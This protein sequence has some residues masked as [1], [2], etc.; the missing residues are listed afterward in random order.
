VNNRNVIQ[1]FEYQKISLGGKFK[2]KHLKALLK[3]N[4]LH[5]FNYLEAKGNG[6]SF[7]NYVGIVQLDELIIEI[8]PKIDSHDSSNVNWRDVLLDM[9]KVTRKL[10]AHFNESAS[11]QTRNKD[12]LEVYLDLFLTEIERLQKRGLV[13]K[14]RLKTGNTLS[15]KGKLEIV[16][17]IKNNLVHKERFYT[18]HQVYDQQH[19]IH[20]ILRKCITI[21]VDLTRY[22]YLSSKASRVEMTFPE[23][24]FSEINLQSFEKIHLNKKTNCYAIAL[25][26]ARIILENFSP[27]IKAGDC[28][29][30][31]LLFD[32]NHLWEKYVFTLL[33]KG[34]AEGGYRLHSSSK[35][36]LNNESYS[37]RPD[38]YIKFSNGLNLIID[39]KWK[40]PRKRKASMVDLRQIYTYNHF[41][42]SEYGVL[43]YPGYREN[44]NWMN[45]ADG[46]NNLC[47]KLVFLD[48]LKGDGKLNKH[49]DITDEIGLPD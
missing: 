40:V 45:F 4:E 33:K 16:G 22:S 19:L 27:S 20:K 36:L 18:T 43:L 3:L 14:Y 39:T 37:L 34:Q 5:S 21:V 8:L 25:D 29:M 12:L 30:L 44:S 28:N 49:I 15:L 46:N 23:A 32:M 11:V 24:K 9:L 10:K 6:V 38:M 2:S 26:L 48:I 1:V 42:G 47:C 7:K 35:P 31:A 13:K 41:W 17:H